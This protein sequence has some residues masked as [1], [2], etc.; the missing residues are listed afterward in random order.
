MDSLKSLKIIMAGLAVALCFAGFLALTTTS[1]ATLGSVEYKYNPYHSNGAGG[2]TD[3][4][5][6]SGLV[7]TQ[8]TNAGVSPANVN[9]FR[10]LVVPY[11]SLQYPSSAMMHLQLDTLDGAISGT[12]SN[13]FIYFVIPEGKVANASTI[14]I[15]KAAFTTN[16]VAWGEY[17]NVYCMITEWAGFVQCRRYGVGSAADWPAVSNLRF[18]FNQTFEVIDP[19]DAHS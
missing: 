19:V 10:Y 16:G 9:T 7:W 1:H 15:A 6:T 8:P 14:V 12:R 13:A 2:S 18:S 4:G 3:F 11:P 5:G 17:E